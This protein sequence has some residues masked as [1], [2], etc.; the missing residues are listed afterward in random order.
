MSRRRRDVG[1]EDDSSVS[2]EDYDSV[3]DIESN[4]SIDEKI[5]EKNNISE[6]EESQKK[7]SSSDNIDVIKPGG[8]RNVSIKK[9]PVAVPRSGKFF[10]HDDRGASN[11]KLGPKKER[12]GK[13]YVYYFN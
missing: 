9:N 12:L 8:A 4:G 10:L 1:D 2:D 7:Q 13:S 11:Q 5:E 6:G 3:S